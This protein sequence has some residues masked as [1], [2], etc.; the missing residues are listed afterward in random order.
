M[1]ELFC[2]ETRYFL[3]ADE[4]KEQEVPSGR[5]SFYMEGGGSK[6][7]HERLVK[8]RIKFLIDT[9]ENK[10]SAW[11][12]TSTISKIYK[13]VDRSPIHISVV[14]FRIRESY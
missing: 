4:F 8:E 1:D 7:Q 14:H 6:E 13:Y 10:Y 11:V 5:F 2:L 12:H 3:L 9:N